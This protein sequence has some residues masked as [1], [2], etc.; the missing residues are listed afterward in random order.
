[1]RQTWRR[2]SIRPEAVGAPLE[3]RIEQS[4]RRV[5]QAAHIRSGSAPHLVD[6][7]FAIVMAAAR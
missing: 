6:G 2:S 5:K 7:C 3:Q 4:H 1:M